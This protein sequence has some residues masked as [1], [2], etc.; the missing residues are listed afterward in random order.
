MLFRLGLLFHVERGSDQ[1]FKLWD[2]F[3]NGPA[4]HNAL[5]HQLRKGF[6]PLLIVPL[7]VLSLLAYLQVPFDLE[8]GHAADCQENDTDADQD[9]LEGVIR[10]FFD[11]ALTFDS[12]VY[13]WVGIF[14]FFKRED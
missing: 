4:D 3:T 12:L 13:F 10:L 1:S 8:V 6:L 2:F 11:L 5:G 7:M 14:G 9:D